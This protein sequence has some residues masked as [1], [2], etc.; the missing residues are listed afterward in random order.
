MAQ[1]E[2][3]VPKFGSA[4]SLSLS[5]HIQYIYIY[6]YKSVTEVQRQIRFVRAIPLRSPIQEKYFEEMTQLAS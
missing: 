3:K 2:S 5:W 6:M 1:T 4:P